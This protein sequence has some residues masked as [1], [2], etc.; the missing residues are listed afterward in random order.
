MKNLSSKKF[1]KTSQILFALSVICTWA[2]G[3]IGLIVFVIIRAIHNSS[4]KKKLSPGQNLIVPSHPIMNSIGQVS[5]HF[6]AFQLIDY[7]DIVIVVPAI[8]FLVIGLTL[9]IISYKGSV[10]K[11]DTPSLGVSSFLPL[12]A[13]KAFTDAIALFRQ[14][15]RSY[16]LNFT[17]ADLNEI[18][19]SDDPLPAMASKIKPGYPT[20]DEA[21]LEISKFIYD[22]MSYMKVSE[23]EAF[24]IQF[25]F[26]E[27]STRFT[28]D[29]IREIA[30]DFSEYVPANMF[31]L[32]C[33][34]NYEL[35]ALGYIMQ[36]AIDNNNKSLQNKV[37]QYRRERGFIS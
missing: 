11:N 28:D 6:A 31:F 14:L 23:L 1:F 33:K 37:T 7:D 20:V 34:I 2:F 36:F 25:Q 35:A 8:L 30:D 17:E 18:F 10:S 22:I 15:S 29:T 16:G 5:M 9:Y 32:K 27:D 3:L 12:S 21:C 13:E 4:C 24:Q 26:T 19:L